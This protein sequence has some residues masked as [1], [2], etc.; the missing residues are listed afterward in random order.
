METSNNACVTGAEHAPACGASVLT[1]WFAVWIP[2]LQVL[3][4]NSSEFH[5]MVQE[6][7]L[8]RLSTMD[9]N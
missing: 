9:R 1:R 6:S 3:V 7:R 4:R 2:T 8:E 5:D